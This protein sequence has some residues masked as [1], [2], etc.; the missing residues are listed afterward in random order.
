MLAEKSNL[1]WEFWKQKYLLSLRETSPLRHKGI[2][3]QLNQQTKLGQV[4]I[5]KDDILTT[6]GV[7]VSPN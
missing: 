1:F 5:V 3:S 7:K 6:Q 2:R 4:V